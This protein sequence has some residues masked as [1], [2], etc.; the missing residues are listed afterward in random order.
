MKNSLK[1]RKKRTESK[2]DNID[3]NFIAFYICGFLIV[4]IFTPEEK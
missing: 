2:V 4:H 3:G 1:T